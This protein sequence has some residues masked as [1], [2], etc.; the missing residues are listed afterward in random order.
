MQWRA[1][2]LTYLR[3]S[4]IAASVTRACTKDGAKKTGVFG[5]ST[6]KIQK[7]ENGKPLIKILNINISVY[8]R[9]TVYRQAMRQHVDLY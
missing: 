9:Q 5:E 4:Q 2:G 8:F 7:W 1:A 3:F 6:L